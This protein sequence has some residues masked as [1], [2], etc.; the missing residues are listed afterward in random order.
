MSKKIPERK[1]KDRPSFLGDSA[2]GKLQN[3]TQQNYTCRQPLI[4]KL[5]TQFGCRIYVYFT[6]F[7]PDQVGVC[8]GD[9]EMLENILSV[10]HD[11][12][13]LLLIIN[14]P[15]GQALAAERIVNTCRAYSKDRFSVLV[16]HMAKSGAT[17][18]TFGADK[19]YMSK[20][21]ELGPVDPQVQYFSDAGE[22]IWTS[23]AEYIRAYDKLMN[24]GTSGD[25]KRLEPILQQLVRFDAREIEIMRSHQALSED[26]SVKLLKS[27][28]MKHASLKEIRKRIT[29]F[30]VQEKTSSHGRMI[31]YE[32]ARRCRLNVELIDLYTPQWDQIWELYV[33]CD[34]AVRNTSAALIETG[35]LSLGRRL[36]KRERTS[37]KKGT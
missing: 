15:G 5:R 35:D 36:I 1:D 24:K 6:S 30:L 2:W 9:V 11:G 19:I 33:R 18:I 27:G 13:K 17:L 21:A 31:T 34:W 25:A 3:E 12:G 23:A 10:E 32:E 28:M 16:P 29:P 7:S 22:P 4:Q 8:D 37:P 26:M 14:S 20:T